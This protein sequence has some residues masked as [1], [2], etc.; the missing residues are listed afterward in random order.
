MEVFKIIQVFL[1][2]TVK[3]VLTFPYA[4][5]IGLNFEQTLI[6]VTLGGLVGFFFFYHFS[7]FALKQFHHVKTFVWKHSPRF[8]RF[9]YRQLCAWRKRMTGEKVFTKTNRFIVKFR[10]KYGLIGII[11]ASPVILSLPIGAFLLNKYYPKHKLV[12]PYM[13]LSILSWAAVFVA[14][15]IIF[16]HLVR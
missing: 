8:L 3:Y 1:L 2:A 12:M 5:M 16:P 11:V 6:S 10:T 9:K 14:F 7:G 13:I 4:L 15:A